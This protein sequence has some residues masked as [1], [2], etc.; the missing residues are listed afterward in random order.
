MS[1]STLRDMKYAIYILFS[2]Y[3]EVLQIVMK[4]NSKL[5]GQAFVVFSNVSSATNAR[6]A[7]NGT[8]FFDK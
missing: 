7:I 1:I 2:Q 5:R 3:G 6:A 8:S 4:K